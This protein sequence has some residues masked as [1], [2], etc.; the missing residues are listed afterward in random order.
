[1]SWEGRAFRCESSW[2]HPPRPWNPAS[3]LACEA[4]SLHLGTCDKGGGID[5]IDQEVQILLIASS[6][7]R[8]NLYQVTRGLQSQSNTETGFPRRSPPGF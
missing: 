5:Q 3:G 2:D 4:L 1:M 7:H 6:V 8:A